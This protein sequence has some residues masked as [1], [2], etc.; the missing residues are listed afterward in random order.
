MKI[1]VAILATVGAVSFAYGQ[2]TVLVDNRNGSKITPIFLADGTTEIKG[3]TYSAA[4]IFNGAQVGDAYPFQANG[5]FASGVGVSLPG[6][7]EGAT[8]NGL[9]LHAWDN[10]TGA[11]YDAATLKGAS[12]AFNNPTGG[13]TTPPPSLTGLQSFN[14]SGTA[15]PATTPGPGSGPGTSPGV[16]EPSTIALGVLGAAALLLRVRK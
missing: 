13:G 8:A 11:T 4:L 12:A 5:R 15:G 3:P 9:I 16:P 6:V 14:I 10:T 7:A 1:S 2:A